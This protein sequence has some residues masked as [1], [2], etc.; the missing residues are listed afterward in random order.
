VSGTELVFCYNRDYSF[1]LSKRADASAF[2]IESFQGNTSGQ[3]PVEDK[4]MQH[5]LWTF[6][7]AP[8]SLY[9]TPISRLLADENF[10][11]RS[12]S[13]LDRDQ[14]KMVRLEFEMRGSERRPGYAGWMVVSPEEGWILREYNYTLDRSG[15][16]LRGNVEYGDSIDGGRLPRRVTHTRYGVA[17]GHPVSNRESADFSEL[18]LIGLPDKEFTLEAFGLPNFRPG[19]GSALQGGYAVWMIGGSV[20]L[21]TL[22]LLLRAA[23]ARVPAG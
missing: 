11:V 17:D 5:R 8:Y 13:R 10:V 6:L 7:C 22:A 16:I 4:N 3:I 14:Q 12:V 19:R 18:R 23:G 15:T 1:R 21:M 2:T 9:L 20:L